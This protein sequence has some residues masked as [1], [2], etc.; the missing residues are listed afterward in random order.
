MKLIIDTSTNFIYLA[1]ADKNI[2]DESIRLSNNNASEYIIDDIDKLLK[3]NNINKT[4]L[5]SIIVGAGPGSYTGIRIS[6]TIAKMLAYFL[7][8]KLY[9]ISSLFL[10][11]SGYEEVF[12]YIDARN[13]NCFGIYHAKNSIILNDGFYNFDYINNRLPNINKVKLDDTTFKINYEKILTKITDV[14]D[15]ELFE[16]NYLRLTQAERERVLKDVKLIIPVDNDFDYINYSALKYFNIKDYGNY[17]KTMINNPLLQCYILKDEFNYYGFIYFSIDEDK[18][19]I[20]QIC[21]EEKY[22]QIGLAKILVDKIKDN[23][24]SITLEVRVSNIVAI[25]FYKKLDFK[26]INTK[27]AYYNNPIEDAYYMIW[28]AS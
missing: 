4:S 1:L 2:I 23:T 27:K 19:D 10:L 14:I 3:K 9:S 28:R 5:T 26:I 11:S 13:N 22:R 25:D 16:P 7:N 21:I 6:V 18:A 12:A 17:I 15:I 24:N 20:Y 8:I